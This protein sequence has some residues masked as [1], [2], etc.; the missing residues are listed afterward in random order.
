M[1]ALA[2]IEFPPIQ[3]MNRDNVAYL[4]FEQELAEHS[5]EAD[6]VRAH[7]LIGVKLMI[8][9]EFE[10]LFGDDSVRIKITDTETGELI[11]V[12]ALPVDTKIELKSWVETLTRNTVERIQMAYPIQ[13]RLRVDSDGPKINVGENV[14]VVEGMRFSVLTGSGLEH[15]LK[16]ISITILDFVGPKE[17]RVALNG[18][19]DSAIPE[20]G[21]YVV[22]DSDD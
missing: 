21:W 1:D 13:G 6:R 8:E 4:L 14:G 11:S 22:E 15:R 10:Y 7:R 16:D 12:P 18:F 20:E 9:S 5:S 2:E 19:S 3:V 17:A